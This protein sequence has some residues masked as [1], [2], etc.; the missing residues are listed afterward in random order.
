VNAWYARYP[1]D[2]LRDTAHLSLT[3]HDAYGLLL[4]HYYSTEKPLPNNKDALY[5]ICRALND[6]QRLRDQQK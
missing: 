1:G 3:E 4:D 5:P 6:G 2:Y